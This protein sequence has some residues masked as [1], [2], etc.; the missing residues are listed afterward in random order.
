MSESDELMVANFNKS[1]SVKRLI[2]QT[3]GMFIPVLMKAV[4]IELSLSKI[5]KILIKVT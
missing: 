5:D 4:L 1:L 3:E 2:A